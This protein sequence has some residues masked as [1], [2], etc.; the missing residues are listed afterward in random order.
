MKVDWSFLRLAGY[1][2]VGSAALAY[3]PLSAFATPDV[4]DG[5]I[6]GGIVGFLNLMLG[7][8]AIEFGFD[9]SNTTFLK[10]VLGGMVVRLLLMWGALAVMLKYYDFHEAS[11]IFALLFMYIMALVLEIYYLQKK[12]AVKS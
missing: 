7:Y 9:K 8:A 2:V 4:I 5:V 12:V 10:I 1:C 6:A 11:L 3:Y